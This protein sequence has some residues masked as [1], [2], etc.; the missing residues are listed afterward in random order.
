MEEIK[1]FEN[2]ELPRIDVPERYVMSPVELKDFVP[3]DVKRVYYITQ[4][5]GMTGAHCHYI[6]E[7]FFIMVKGTCVA[8]IDYG[9]GVEE[10]EMTGPQSAMYVPN[11]V[12]HGFTDFSEDAVLLALSSTNYNPD[13]SDYLEDYDEYM[14]IRDEH[15]K[16][17]A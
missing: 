8:T 3:F 4:P 1:Q 13:R 14:K 17:D 16:A 11:Y 5:V 12:W 10:F 2:I 6:E 7:E 15:L 9:N